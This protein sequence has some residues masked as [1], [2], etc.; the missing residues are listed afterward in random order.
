MEE[1]KECERGTG[2]EKESDGQG[3]KYVGLLRGGV[4]Q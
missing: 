1:E 3:E 2:E 4:N